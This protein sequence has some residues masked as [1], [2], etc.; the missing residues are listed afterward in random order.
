MKKNILVGITAGVAIYKVC[1][2]IRKLKKEQYNVK[3]IMTQNATKLISSLLFQELSNDKVYIDMF[4][5]YEY[6]PLHISLS[7]WADL[8]VV[9]PCS[10]NT[11]SKLAYGKTEDLLTSTIYALDLKKTKVLICPS[12]NTNMWEHPVTQ[13]NVRLLKNIGYEVL[14]PKEGELLCDIKGKGRLP[15]VDEILKYIKKLL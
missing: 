14:Q 4:S 11:I 5:E 10:C 8:V 12:M 9:V 3:C 15:E 6:S 2:L 1:E 13:N 7:K